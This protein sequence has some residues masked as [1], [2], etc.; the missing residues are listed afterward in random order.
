MKVH[1]FESESWIK[2]VW[3]DNESHVENIWVEGSL[4]KDVA[5]QYQDAEIICS[6][7]SIL[8]KPTL[9]ELHQLKLIALRSTGTDQ[10]DLDY[11]EAD[12]ITVCNVPVYAQHAV[13][14]Q[15]FTLLLALCRHVVRATQQ[16]R[17]FNFSW[18][19]LQGLE[20]HGKTMAV[21][22]TGAIGKRVTAIANGFGMRVVAFDKF[23]DK[24]WALNHRV[25]YVSL[26]EALKAADIVSLHVPSSPDTYHLLSSA[27]FE[28]MR[29]GVLLIN[30]ARGELVDSAAL[31]K[32]LDSGKVAAAGLD[33]L[34]HKTEL[35]KLSESGHPI[36]DD[37][38]DPETRL[39]LR[40]LQ[41]P[42]VLVTPHS[43]FFTHEASERLIKTTMNN[44]K[45]FIKGKPQNI[46][47]RKHASF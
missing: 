45:A 27:R 25:N 23:P 24:A 35:L 20:L 5:S 41:H 39:S 28:R 10:V 47:F 17:K 18:D 31:L 6:D 11:C 37:N 38:L 12:Q 9:H 14:E 30:T 16:T 13:A 19:N 32:A 21:I 2:S 22:G 42:K 44:I 26:D 33:V 1:V 34:P 40:L 29:D 7:V 4:T 46:V 15:T 8:D 36:T 43:A 3:Q